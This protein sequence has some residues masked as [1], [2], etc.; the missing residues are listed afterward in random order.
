MKLNTTRCHV[1]E[2]EMSLC[3]FQSMEGEVH[4]VRVKIEGMPVMRCPEGHKRFVVPDF[5]VK[6][7][8]ALLED[9]RLV[10]IDPASQKGLLRKRYCCPGCGKELEGG[11][12]SRAQATRLLELS[13]L[14]AFG[15]YVELPKLRCSVC[16]REYVPPGEVIV[17]DLMKASTRAFRA[18]AVSAT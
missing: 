17:D 16:C 4:D 1:C 13:G 2:K 3:T 14:E 5:A 12:S 10:P 11:A 15:V 9:D 7:M 8:E 18:A 6:L